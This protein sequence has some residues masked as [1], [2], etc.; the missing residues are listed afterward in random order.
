MV[1]ELESL[2]DVSLSLV[3]Y[4]F[5]LY[6]FLFFFEEDD[7]VILGLMLRNEGESLLS[8]SQRKKIGKEWVDF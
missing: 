4:E 8:I 6:G 5:C 1:S 3:A 2:V 7:F